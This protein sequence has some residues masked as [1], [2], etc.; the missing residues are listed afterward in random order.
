MESS[1]E[2]ES[3]FTIKKKS[4]NPLDKSFESD[5]SDVEMNEK[6]KDEPTGDNKASKWLVSTKDTKSKTGKKTKK[7]RKEEKKGQK[8]KKDKEVEVEEDKTKEKESEKQKEEIW[9]AEKVDQKLKEL[10]VNR[11]KKVRFRHHFHNFS[12]LLFSFLPSHTSYFESFIS[13]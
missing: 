3:F 12:S 7:E 1:D 4:T 11:G 9:T 13:H 2:D 6:S 5:E 8:P 10:L